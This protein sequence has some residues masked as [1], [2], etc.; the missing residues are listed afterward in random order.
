M[1]HFDKLVAELVAMTPNKE[2]IGKV[3]LQK[4][5]YLLGA[6]G[7]NTG[8]SFSYHHY[9]PYSR[10]LDIGTDEALSSSLINEVQRDLAQGGASYS[11]F[12]LA[13]NGHDLPS[14]DVGS[15]DKLSIKQ[16]LLKFSGT[17]SMILELAATAHW[18]AEVE[19]V[20]DW[21]SELIARKGAKTNNGRLERA[22]DLLKEISLSPGVTVS[23][24]VE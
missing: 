19:K 7:L 10:D 13:D 15:L 22:I 17:S 9:G 20:S 8:L 23:E 3:R 24:P 16:L 5:A 18:L 11:V 14:L 2:L 12:T 21:R 6:K 1:T 4:T